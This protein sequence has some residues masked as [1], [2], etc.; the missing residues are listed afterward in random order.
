MRCDLFV[1]VFRYFKAC[2]F[3]TQVLWIPIPPIKCFNIKAYIA[4]PIPI[5]YVEYRTSEYVANNI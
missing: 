2:E 1:I 3:P 4:V 5:Y